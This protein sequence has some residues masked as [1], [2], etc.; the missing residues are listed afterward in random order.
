MSAAALLQSDDTGLS[1]SR[2]DLVVQTAEAIGDQIR[3]AR[4]LESQ[5]RMLMDVAPGRD[6]PGAVDWTEGA[7]TSELGQIR[8]RTQS[9]QRGRRAMQTVRPCWISACENQVQSSRGTISIRSRSILTGS[10]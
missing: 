8:L 6:Q 4:L 2:G 1:D 10:S 7:H 3:G 5:L 9:A